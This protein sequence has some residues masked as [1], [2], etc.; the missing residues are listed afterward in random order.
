MS[1]EMSKVTPEISVLIPYYNDR[2][3]LRQSIQMV[4]S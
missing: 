4:L 1:L 2:A 3:F